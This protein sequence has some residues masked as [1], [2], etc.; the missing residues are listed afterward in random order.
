VEFH[1]EEALADLSFGP[2][3][4]IGLQLFVEEPDL[5]VTGITDAVGFVMKRERSAR[6]G[7]E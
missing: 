3:G 4:R 2:R 7:M 5:A 1:D 6:R